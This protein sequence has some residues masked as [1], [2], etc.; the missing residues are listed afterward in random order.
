MNKV[1]ELTYCCRTD[2]EGLDGFIQQ[3]NEGYLEKTFVQEFHLT[4]RCGF[5][6]LPKELIEV[7]SRTGGRGCE[8]D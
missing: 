8:I 5:E 2:V 3:D 7:I 4:N 6:T 1:I